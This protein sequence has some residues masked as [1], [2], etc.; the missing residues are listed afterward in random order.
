MWEKE[1][2]KNTLIEHLTSSVFSYNDDLAIK[3]PNLA[4]Q[5]FALAVYPAMA[6]QLSKKGYF[7]LNPSSVYIQTSFSFNGGVD[8]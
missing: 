3:I 4:P 1:S 2:T 5:D 8:L 7:D 6:L